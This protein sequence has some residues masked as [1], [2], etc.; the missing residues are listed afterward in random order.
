MGE[1]TR[2]YGGIHS[3]SNRLCVYL[4]VLSQWRKEKLA[5]YENTKKRLQRGT[6]EKLLYHSCFPVENGHLPW[7]RRLSRHSSHSDQSRVESAGASSWTQSS[8]GSPFPRL[9]WMR[10]RQAV[11]ETKG[12]TQMLNRDQ[13]S[14]PTSSNKY[15]RTSFISIKKDTL[16][17][18]LQALTV[19][20]L[21]F[22]KHHYRRH[23][24][25]FFFF[26]H[27]K[28]DKITMINSY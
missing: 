17:F 23:L 10:L 7:S 9:T 1:D 8:S 25:L 28:N 24:S 6:Q 26:C 15:V 19:C 14:N 11:S 20:F 4:E 5:F 12:C 21:T 2:F 22:K 3:I 27:E 13:E 16:S 18:F